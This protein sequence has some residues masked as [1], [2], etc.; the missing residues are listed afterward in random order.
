MNERGISALNSGRIKGQSPELVGL[1]HFCKVRALFGYGD[2]MAPGRADPLSLNALQKIKKQRLRFD[3]LSE[4]AGKSENGALQI[5]VFGDCAYRGRI[6]S[7]ED[8]N[9]LPS[10]FNERFKT[11]FAA[12]FES[13]MATNTNPRSP[14]PVRSRRALRRGPF[15]Y[16]SRREGPANSNLSLCLSFRLR[17]PAKAK[18]PWPRAGGPHWRQS[19]R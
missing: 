15:A 4:F 1:S 5:E 14:P 8:E 18:H 6:D 12:R 3:V 10:F 19:V 9:A 7:V 17:R 2:K 16:L 11:A 13:P